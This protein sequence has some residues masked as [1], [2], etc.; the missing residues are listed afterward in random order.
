MATRRSATSRGR[1]SG[2]GYRSPLHKTSQ[3]LIGEEIRALKSQI[4][5]EISQRNSGFSGGLNISLG[6]IQEEYVAELQ[7]LKQRTRIFERMINDPHVRGQLR[8]IAMTLISGVRWKVDGG[9]Q[10]QRDLLGANILR[11][12]PPKWWATTSWY[13]RLYESLGMMIYG[14]A[15]FGITRQ[16]VDDKMILRNIKWLHPRS[17]DEN[18]WIMDGADNLIEVRRTFHDATGMQFS[19]LPIAADDMFLMCWDRRGPNWEGNAFIR[20]MYKPWKFSELAEK[21]DI[22]DLQNRGIAIPVAHLSGAGGPKERDTLQEIL[23]SLRGA[24]KDRAFIVL[25]KDEKIDF[26]TSTGTAK[27][28]TEAIDRHHMGVAKAGGTEY[29]EVSSSISGA[30]RAAASVLATG[31]FINIDAIRIIIEDMINFGVGPLKGLSEMVQDPNFDTEADKFEYARI[32]GSRVSPTEQFDNIPLIQDSVKAFLIPPSL[33]YANETARRLGWPEITQQEFDHGMELMGKG[34]QVQGRPGEAGADSNSSRGDKLS[35]TAPKVGESTPSVAGPIGAMEAGD[36]D[37]VARRSLQLAGTKGGE[38]LTGRPP[39]SEESHVLALAE[40]DTTL[41]STEAKY[42]SIG[43]RTQRRE[44]EN[45]V[46]QVKNGLTVKQLLAENAAGTLFKY[47]NQL[48][49]D[50]KNILTQVRNFGIGQVRDEIKRAKKRGAVAIMDRPRVGAMN[51]NHDDQGRFAE[52]GAI[53]PGALKPGDP[54]PNTYKDATFVGYQ[55]GPKPER[56]IRFALY[57]LHKDIPG[58]TTNST[59]T[60]ETL[61]EHGFERH[62]T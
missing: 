36:P 9:T 6:D 53:R 61:K 56:K 40:I 27:S 14:F 4:A 30:G 3:E 38:P 1:K 31:F 55:R 42:A 5:L 50:W 16:I 44:I 12:G 49:N 15:L 57:N 35:G 47:R 46:E 59:V 39:T 21:I 23:R 45:I 41:K 11:D 33:K 29:S 8:G 34:S 26:L 18:G 2:G 48:G 7:P 58:H 54:H 52:T 20:P 43:H 24:N 19:R 17:V 62:E 60:E 22:I 25:E 32:V 13:D 10:Q 51:P 37:P 28:A